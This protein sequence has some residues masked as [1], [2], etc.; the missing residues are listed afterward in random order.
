MQTVY[1][2]LTDMVKPEGVRYTLNQRGVGRVTNP[3][4]QWDSSQVDHPHI[5]TE[6]EE[7]T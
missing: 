4:G 1:K 5:T 6:H 3:I 7:W 2:N